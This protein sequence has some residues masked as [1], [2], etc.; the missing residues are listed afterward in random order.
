[1]S[2]PWKTVRIFISSTFRDMHAE[3][4]LLVHDVF[5]ELRER[6][7]KQHLHLVDVD[8]RWGVTEEE[9][10]Q[11]KVLEIC[12]DEIE[13]CR[14]FFIGL[15]GERYGWVPPKYEVTDPQ[16]Y[17]WLKELDTNE[18][19]VSVTALEIYHGVLRSSLMKTRAFFYFRDPSFLTDARFLS[20]V[21]AEKQKDFLPE[22]PGAAIKLKELKAEIRRQCPVFENYPCDF[23]G[24]DEQSHVR[25]TNLDTFGKRVL[26]DLWEAIKAEHP[27]EELVID[28]VSRE[29]AYHDAF[30]EARTQGFVGRRDV[31]RQL[32]QFTEDSSQSLLLVTGKAGAG[33]SA[34]LAQFAKEFAAQH[35]DA[36]VIAHFI[37]AG[38][39]STDI[40]R[41]LLRLCR[42][43]TSEF[44][45]QNDIPFDYSKLRQT[46]KSFLEEASAQ[47]RVLLIIDA[48]NQLDE[49]HESHA[50]G[51]LP[52][53]LPAGSKV[54]VS[55]I[56]DSDCVAALRSR[57][58]APAELAVGALNEVEQKEIVRQTL[59]VYRKRLEEKSD[60][61]QLSG[62]LSKHQ[63]TSPLYLTV[64]C[65]EMRVFG[66]FEKLTARINA[67]PNDVDTLFEQ[68]LERIETDHETVEPTKGRER[69]KLAL[70]LLACSRHGLLESEMLSL[71]AR[72]GEQLL[73]AAIWARL[74]RPLQFYLRPPGETGEGML[75]FFHQQL[76]HAVRKRYLSDGGATKRTHQQLANYFR[77]R[78]NPLPTEHWSTTYPRGLS[79]LPYHLLAGERY[80]E[81]LQIARDE[82]FL[83]AQAQSFDDDPAV[84]L[85]TL[86]NAIKAS[87]IIDDG[88]ALAEFVLSHA[89]RSLEVKQESPLE[90]L[91][92]GHLT[93]AWELADMHDTEKC[94]LWHLLFAFE[95]HKRHDEEGAQS[96]IERLLAKPL[97]NLSFEYDDYGPHLVFL[98][99]EQDE[100]NFW[101]L[102]ERLLTD[103]QR[104]NLVHLFISQSRSSQDPASQSLL[105]V[106]LEIA[107]LIETSTYRAKALTELAATHDKAEQADIQ[108]A[109][110]SAAF[111]ATQTIEGANERIAALSELA[112]AQAQ[113]GFH[114]SSRKTFAAASAAIWDARDQSTAL[115]NLGVAQ[116]K[117]L[118]FSDALETAEKINDS[119]RR[120]IVLTTIG[121]VEVKEQRMKAAQ[122]NFEA[123][124]VAARQIQNRSS[125]SKALRGIVGVL[126]R[127]NEIS[128]A[129]K[130]ASTIEGEASRDEAFQDIAVQQ[131]RLGDI[132]GANETLSSIKFDSFRNEAIATDASER[133]LAQTRAAAFENAVA[134][135][136]TLEGFSKA[137]LLSEIGIAMAVAGKEG[138]AR[139]T[140]EQAV[141]IAVNTPQSFT[142]REESKARLL[143]DIATAQ[144]NAGQWENAV[145]TIAL[146]IGKAKQ[147]YGR[148]RDLALQAITLI[149]AQSGDFTGALHTTKQVNFPTGLIK[150]IAMMQANTHDFVGAVEAAVLITSVEDRMQLLS[151]I[152][153]IWLALEDSDS[154]L[155]IFDSELTKISSLEDELERSDGLKEVASALAHL[156]EFSTALEIADQIPSMSARIRT[157]NEIAQ[158]QVRAGLGDAAK[159]TFA[160]AVQKANGIDKK[161]YRSQVL[162]EIAS[163]Q[164]QL[165]DLTGGL[166]TARRIEVEKY[167][168]RVMKDIALSLHA[169]GLHET[170]HD[171]LNL[172]FEAAI[173]IDPK[174]FRERRQAL[175]DVATA[176]WQAS[177]LSEA[178]V[179]TRSIDDPAERSDQLIWIIKEQLRK[180]ELDSA[181][182]TAEL[183]EFRQP[184]A[185]A[186][187]L[188]ATAQL[189]SDERATA[190]RTFAAAL[191]IVRGLERE[192]AFVLRELAKGLA[193]VQDFVAALET[194]RSIELE[195]YRDEA[196][197]F[198]SRRQLSQKLFESA[199]DTASQIGDYELQ[200]VAFRQTATLQFLF[201]EF[202]QSRATFRK[203]IETSQKILDRHSRAQALEKIV[204]FQV[205]C[206]DFLGAKETAQVIDEKE[207]QGS[208]LSRIAVGQARTGHAEEAVTTAL[209]ITFSRNIHLAK[210]AAVL[211]AAGE[212]SAFKRLAMDCAEQMETA[213]KTCALIAQLY[214][215]VAGRIAQ[216]I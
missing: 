181:L 177:N 92:G 210:L 108:S 32:E 142:R 135:A 125:R 129:M 139:G 185:R 42:E 50:I 143:S 164:A 107:N 82:E 136:S 86:Q 186:L 162:E 68:V 165:G 21:P 4:D 59:S 16:R 182:E 89:R 33:K 62:L 176:Q 3:R 7:A 209:S 124:I 52:R 58:A 168:A 141:R 13:R 149:Q 44:N 9:E 156:N 194:A 178:L 201:R 102:Q 88:A 100:K 91:R 99:Y 215:Q 85:E 65:E 57:H 115:M 6:C 127:V 22:S 189:L 11:G 103:R 76:G 174:I 28:E 204:A 171:A 70:S 79:E 96:T 200:T 120:A 148:D 47:R 31:L 74:Y 180:N 49:T 36:F 169:A 183:I 131:A 23:G 187:V 53:S 18:T 179:T 106:A 191:T 173:A 196:V 130:I 207:V 126:A 26:E 111:E 30:V 81:L 203:A 5:L 132:E 154:V 170:A 14:P 95:L 140:F 39:G 60:N 87:A 153:K 158:Q 94:A 150:T 208:A 205:R 146:S 167:R 41:T 155:G 206:R 98:I 73:P 193:Q 114:E 71:L 27:H 216:L 211:V 122:A 34:V 69:V 80:P 55:A 175:K 144:L 51:W 138:E 202:E 151:D 77:S 166:D 112:L 48:L 160:K 133:A 213:Y 214:P 24:V 61:D 75:D 40:R 157:L 90:S 137:R 46:F 35:P 190:R 197:A 152:A 2:R 110:F 67:L 45:L 134:T 195:P 104:H 38:P 25:L 145:T 118:E 192:N 128:N 199:L 117:A 15:L 83:R 119:W 43:L 101:V 19:R 97:K 163:A 105:S 29:R 116:A 20:E 172:A 10:K 64:A 1:M 54:I 37:G 147:V 66:E 84:Q 198:I 8:L 56:D 188:I 78:S 12:L 161:L 121:E 63:A 17:E 72:E 184:K 212:K 159:G 113:A 93:R 109:I 123:A